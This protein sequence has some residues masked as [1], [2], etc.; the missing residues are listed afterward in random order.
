MRSVFIF[1][2]LCFSLTFIS[3]CKCSFLFNR[4]S[5]IAVYFTYFNTVCHL[6]KNHH[7]WSKMSKKKKKVDLDVTT[8]SYCLGYLTKIIFRRKILNHLDWSLFCGIQI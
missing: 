1:V 2:Y 3:Y 6:Y 4:F 7:E 5:S 8:S